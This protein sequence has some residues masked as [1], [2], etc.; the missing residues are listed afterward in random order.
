MLAFE[1]IA[2]WFP[3]RRVLFLAG[4]GIAVQ[5][6][7]VL[8]LWYYAGQAEREADRIQTEQSVQELLQPF[9][10]DIR[11]KKARISA[12][13]QRSDP[14]PMPRSLSESIIGLQQLV[15]SAELREAHFVPASESV[16]QKSVIRLDGVL[17]GAPEAFRRFIVLLGDQPWIHTIES[18]QVSAA[19]PVPEYKMTIW[20][21]FNSPE[22][23]NE[24]AMARGK[25]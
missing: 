16:V 14:L 10:M 25:P 13:V 6:C 17:T 19:S 7:V 12:L 1:R 2:L 8:P 9:V 3:L 18:C 5:L 11:Q 24:Q 21:E 20:A 15:E 23:G 4:A 22:A